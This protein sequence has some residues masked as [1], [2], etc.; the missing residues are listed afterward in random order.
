MSKLLSKTQ[1]K[2]LNQAYAAKVSRPEICFV[3]QDVTDAI[4]VGSLFRT[5]DAA[6]VA[7]VILTGQTPQPPHPQLNTT[8][9]GLERSV[10]WTYFAEFSDA[11]AQLKQNGYQIVGIEI[12]T[13]SQLYSDLAYPA[14][15]ALVLGNEALGIYKKNLA[16]CDDLV[17]IP[18][19]G[20][21]QSLNVTIA[22]AILAYH[23]I[24]QHGR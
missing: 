5:A 17:H 20:K 19:F 23:L 6:G 22:G 4:N 12:D 18:M 24:S 11:I 1:V 16:L 10:P 15:V 13:N 8:A 7:E 21:G 14:K 9:R 3:L 2:H